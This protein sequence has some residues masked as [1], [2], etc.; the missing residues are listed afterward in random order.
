MSGLG[1]L[2][3]GIGGLFAGMAESKGYKESA[4]Y[5]RQ[6][7]AITEQSTGLK[8]LAQ[9]RQNYQVAGAGMAA[10]G[11][12]GIKST[13]SAAAVMRSNAQ[14][15]SLSRSLIAEQGKIEEESYNAQAA[16]AEAQAQASESSG[17]FGAIGGIAGMFI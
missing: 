14:Q 6:A 7:A 10:A 2:F 4:D 3:S 15:G 5:Y 1:D 9:N 12:S 17:I 16:Q 13:G 11:A 8:V